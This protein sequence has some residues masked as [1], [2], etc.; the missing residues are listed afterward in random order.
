ML[1]RFFHAACAANDRR[2][3]RNALQEVC[4]DRVQA[5]RALDR[6]L[7]NANRAMREAAK[8]D[9]EQFREAFFGRRDPV[10][11]GFMKGS[12]EL[13]GITQAHH[14]KPSVRTLAEIGQTKYTASNRP[15]APHPMNMVVPI[16]QAEAA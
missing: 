5:I 12:A 8:L 10:H 7:R 9:V 16:R 14:Q 15:A 11:A 6:S 1:T 2:R 4:D 13:F 3:A